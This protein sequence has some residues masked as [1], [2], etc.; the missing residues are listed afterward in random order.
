MLSGVKMSRIRKNELSNE[1][2]LMI[3]KTR[4]KM[5]TDGEEPYTDYIK[6]GDFDL[7]E[8][9]LLQK[10]LLPDNQI[11]IVDNQSLSLANIDA[12]VQTYKTKFKDKLRVIVVDYINVITAKDPL[13][14]ETQLGIAAGLKKIA[15]KHE[16]AVIAPFQTDE[17]GGVRFAKGILDAPD[18]AF[19]LDA[20]DNSIKFECK[21]TRGTRAMDF[22][23]EMDWDSLRILANR[24]IL[25]E[26]K[27]EEDSDGKDLPWG[28]DDL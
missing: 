6:H 14:W 10:P 19:N 17:K 9:K 23:S 18:W 24:N 11:V 12:T 25:T 3:A 5:H 20:G 26:E 15:R 16:I 27:V 28:D 21:K 13:R 7:F 2:K 8:R 1:D 4:S 22:E